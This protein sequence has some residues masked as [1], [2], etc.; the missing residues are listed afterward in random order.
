MGQEIRQFYTLSL[1]VTKLMSCNVALWV[2]FLA[3]YVKGKRS[4]L[5][6]YSK[7]T[8]S[9]INLLEPVFYI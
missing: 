7:Q 6:F 5:Q 4:L 9:N 3:F 8:R 2:Y 1:V